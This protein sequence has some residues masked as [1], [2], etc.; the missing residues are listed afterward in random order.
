MGFGKKK[1]PEEPDDPAQDERFEALLRRLHAD[2][3]AGLR[4]RQKAAH[5]LSTAAAT[6]R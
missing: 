2:N 1:A 3:E 6:A 5:A 4:D